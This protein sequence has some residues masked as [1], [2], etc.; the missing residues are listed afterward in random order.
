VADTV[1]GGR[2]AFARG[3]WAEA[4]AQL[5]GSGCADA[6]D[7]ERLA[8]AAYLVGRDGECVQAWMRAHREWVHREEPGR[9]VRCAFW[10]GIIL[11]LH[12]EV[13]Q[14]GGWLARGQ[15]MVEQA[16]DETGRGYLRVPR[17]L[18]LLGSGDAAGAHAV[19]LEI[20]GIAERCDEPDLLAFGVLCR[21]QA[22]LAAGRVDEGIAALDAVMV[23]VAA[24]EV[25]PIVT[26]I[27]YCAVIEACMD[28]GD[29]PRATEWTGVLQQWCSA[30]PDLVPY[31]GQ[32]LV[33]RSQVLQAHGAW[34]EAVDEAHR[35]CARL[36]QPPHPALGLALYQ[37]AELCRLRGELAEAERAY[38][39]ASREGR[40]PV[41][42][43]ALLR[44]AQGEMKA[45]VATVRRML[46]ESAA[47]LD[48]PVLLAAAI[49]VLLAAG[50]PPGARTV[51]GELAASADAVDTPLLRAE[52]HYAAG[53]VLLAEGA[54][55]EA[56]GPLRRA[57]MAWRELG[58]PFESARARVQ[59]AV[60]CRS[61]GDADGA[62]LELDA[63]RVTFERLGARPELARV[64][65]LTAGPVSRGASPLTPRECQVLRLVA[66]GRTNRQIAAE[67][68]ISEHTVARHLQNIFGKLHLPS[69]A[70]ATAYAY[71]HGLLG[72]GDF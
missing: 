39:S 62:T 57:C 26:G 65:A 46:Q 29:L 37:Q 43:F 19:A 17:F 12:G 2:A 38:R 20:V 8:V 40:E 13:A 52:A 15:R 27:V 22:A 69:R 45:A 70:A 32:C 25:S 28:V 33:H 68:V 51:L 11:L 1:E 35:A 4:Y 30:H 6:D 71:R 67:L 31:R 21:G 59:I 55:G 63:A 66:A 23:P 53:S 34:S 56:L 64:A 14:A 42:G 18:E 72:R 36:S 16:P 49:E 3:A 58:M 50:D 9:A 54:A 5:T 41:P 7:L 47:R 44:M 60:A 48:R 61:L 10:L 24:G